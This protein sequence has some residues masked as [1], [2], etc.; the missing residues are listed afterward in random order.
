M[1]AA[2]AGLYLKTSDENPF[3]SMKYNEDNT[4]QDIYFHTKPYI[5]ILA[6]LNTLHLTY[7]QTEN[8]DLL[9]TFL[10]NPI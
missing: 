8:D 10:K 4:S 3:S 6:W 2:D 7:A 1:T 9:N 5:K